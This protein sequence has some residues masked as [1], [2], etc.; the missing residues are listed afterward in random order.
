[1]RR[2]L[3]SFIILGLATVG[4]DGA[5]FEGA[6]SKAES[7]QAGGKSTAKDDGTPEDDESEDEKAKKTKSTGA[8]GSGGVTGTAGAAT[9]GA[10]SGATTGSPDTISEGGD[11]EGP[12]IGAEPQSELGTA[13]SVL[14]APDAPFDEIS[15]VG[16]IVVRR[17]TTNDGED[18]F[19]YFAD[20]DKFRVRGVAISR[21]ATIDPNLTL[22]PKTVGGK[23]YAE[24]SQK[25]TDP[26]WEPYIRSRAAAIA[27]FLKAMGARPNAKTDALEGK[28]GCE[29]G[30]GGAFVSSGPTSAPPA[31]EQVKVLLSRPG[32]K[33][34]YITLTDAQTGTACDFVDVAK[35]DEAKVFLLEHFK[36]VK[37]GGY[38]WDDGVTSLAE[39][40]C[41]AGSQV[42]CNL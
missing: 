26:A 20:N 14:S 37:A 21:Y 28:D 11:S 18:S 25:L 33:F 3:T 27:R 23:P 31:Y 2:L 40:P 5:S 4:C 16:I 13:L 8:T 29:S 36:F 12:A 17:R 39:A 22:Y 7:T 6:G 9:S 1:M 41:P 19:F 35:F 24:M 15:G 30:D 10:T 38:L 42:I 32:G 34:G